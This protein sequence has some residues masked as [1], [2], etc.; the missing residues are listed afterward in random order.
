MDIFYGIATTT[1][2]VLSSFTL[3]IFQYLSSSVI[4]KAK[5]NHQRLSKYTNLDGGFEYDCN[6]IIKY[7]LIG[8][9]DKLQ[10]NITR[11]RKSFE[12]EIFLLLLVVFASALAILFVLLHGIYQF[13]WITVEFIFG[14]DL[15]AMLFYIYAFISF[16]YRWLS[17]KK[18]VVQ[19]INKIDDFFIKIQIAETTKI[20]QNSS[21]S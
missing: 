12:R 4:K 14:I 21:N 8:R 20:N 15:I 6:S 13:K 1:L 19:H 2:V 17:R 11:I 16:L 10:N 9:Y 5:D 7:D 3:A 18:K